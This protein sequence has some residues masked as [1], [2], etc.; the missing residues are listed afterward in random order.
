M[1]CTSGTAGASTGP[2]TAC[3]RRYAQLGRARPIGHDLPDR[4]G[5]DNDHVIDVSR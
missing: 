2:V 5:A 4:P 3:R 1:A